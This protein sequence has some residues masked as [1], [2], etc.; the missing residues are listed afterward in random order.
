[1][2]GVCYCPGFKAST[3]RLI[4]TDQGKEAPKQSFLED[5]AVEELPCSCM[6][7]ND[8]DAG[9]RR[10]GHP[11]VVYGAMQTQRRPH[12]YIS[13]T[14]RDATFQFQSCGLDFFTIF[15]QP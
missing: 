10:G 14:R 3:G 15:I 7:L 6:S 12:T 1:M 9:S 4:Q 8:L 5:G 13:I 2:C 11:N